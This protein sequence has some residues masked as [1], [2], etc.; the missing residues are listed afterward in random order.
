M[1]YDLR[2]MTER[3]CAGGV[4]NADELLG[5]VTERVQSLSWQ[6]FRPTGK[7][8]PEARF[9][10]LLEDDRD[11]VD[12]VRT[13]FAPQRRAIVSRNRGATPCD[14]PRY[15]LAARRSRKFFSHSQDPDGKIHR[16][17]NQF[18]VGHRTR[19]HTAPHRKSSVI[20]RKFAVIVAAMSPLT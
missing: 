8:N 18:I 17:L 11:F 3:R 10:R 14:L 7:I 12:E 15:D 1:I 6:E 2:L 20:S 9:V 19:F 16:T 5:F 4:K 13:R